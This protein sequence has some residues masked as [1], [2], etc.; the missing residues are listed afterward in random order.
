[1]DK[2]RDRIPATPR[3]A[4]WRAFSSILLAGADSDTPPSA[5]FVETERAKTRGRAERSR[6]FGTLVAAARAKT[7]SKAASALFLPSG[8]FVATLHEMVGL[9]RW[10]DSTIEQAPNIELGR[11]TE[12]AAAGGE[13]DGQ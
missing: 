6:L 2:R 12:R 5:E 4:K 3:H 10:P 13:S 1:M 8:T 11:A 9:V 7:W